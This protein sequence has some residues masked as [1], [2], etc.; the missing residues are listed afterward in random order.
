MSYHDTKKALVQQLL[1]AS[2]NSSDIAVENDK[3]NPKGK[4]LWFAAY[5]IPASTDILGKT[6]ASGDEQR[7]IFQVSV[8]VA[9]NSGDYDFTQLTAID[10]I[11]SAFKFNT[12]TVYNNQAVDILSATVNAGSESDA[13][14][15]RDISIN[16]LTFSERV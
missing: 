10:T 12:K 5:F 4:S 2:I 16:Y 3:F 15:Q 14:F 1:T 9:I 13:W 8:F 6:P 11:L 7:G